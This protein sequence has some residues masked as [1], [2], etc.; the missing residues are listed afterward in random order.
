MNETGT[1]YTGIGKT[2][3]F[4]MKV[5]KEGSVIKVNNKLLKT[6]QELEKNVNY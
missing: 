6:F 3:N 5:L 4:G 1:F 2:K